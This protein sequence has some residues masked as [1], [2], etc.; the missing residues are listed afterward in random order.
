MDMSNK[1]SGTETDS[2]AKRSTARDSLFLVGKLTFAD[3]PRTYEVRIRNLSAT[4]MM[5]ECAAAVAAGHAVVVE[6]K[7]LGEVSGKV[8]WSAEGRLGIAFDFQIDPA[9]ARNPGKLSPEQAMM[10]P[11]YLKK[12]SNKT[13]GHR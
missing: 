9:L 12:L 6:T 4:G 11:D 2:S 10:V 13:P 1:I 7:G 8:A 5:A 3:M